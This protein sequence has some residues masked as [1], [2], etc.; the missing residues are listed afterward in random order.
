MLE[1][2]L[3]EGVVIC[4]YHESNLSR[5]G[6]CEGTLPPPFRQSVRYWCVFKAK[7]GV[8]KVGPLPMGVVSAQACQEQ[9]R[10]LSQACLFSRV[11]SIGRTSFISLPFQFGD[12]VL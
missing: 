5:E 3:L 9:G 2:L 6:K 10:D 4:I 8:C 7:P 12:P 1:G 11:T